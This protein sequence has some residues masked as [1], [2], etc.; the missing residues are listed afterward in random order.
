M[1]RLFSFIA[2]LPVAALCLS[3]KAAWAAAG[4]VTGVGDSRIALVLGAVAAVIVMALLTRHHSLRFLNRFTER[5]GRRRLQRILRGAQLESLD[6]FVLPATG[7]DLT[8]IDH[9]V[10][11]SAGIVC[12]RRKQY[13]G[14]V[15]ANARDPQ[16]L[17]VDGVKQQQFLNPLMQNEGRVAAIRRV[18]PDMPV[19]NLV[20]F[21]GDTEFSVAPA[22]NVI[23]VARLAGWLRRLEEQQQSAQNH[24][25][26]WLTLRAAA[27][28]DEASLRDFEAQ[29]S[30]G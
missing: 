14:T 10:L 12:I 23:S 19:F 18:V 1:P 21:T 30:F 26:A 5:S 11:T 4:S 2:S 20:V 3:H 25:D 13:D 28:T 6:R 15:F 7:G 29:L 24:D 8:R 17:V 27:L 9:A 16:W 22:P